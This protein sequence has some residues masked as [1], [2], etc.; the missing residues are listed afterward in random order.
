MIDINIVK[1]I[2]TSVLL[3]MFIFLFVWVYHPK[4]RKNFEE[5]GKLPFIDGMER[6]DE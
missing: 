6:I 1:G 3:L 2:V 5:K 4:R